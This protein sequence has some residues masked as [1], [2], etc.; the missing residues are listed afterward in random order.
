MTASCSDSPY[1][2]ST[3]GALAYLASQGMQAAGFNIAPSDWDGT[4]PDAKVNADIM[5]QVFNGAIIELHDGQDVLSRDGGH[6]GYL[7]SLLSQPKAAGD[8]FSTM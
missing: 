6:P 3:D 2:Q 5:S 1:N 8:S 4:V 7:P